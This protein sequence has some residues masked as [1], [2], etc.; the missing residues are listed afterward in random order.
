MA[1]LEDSD[2]R[3]SGRGDSNQRKSGG[4]YSVTLSSHPSTLAPAAHCSSSSSGIIPDK[5][6][7][8]HVGVAEILH[9]KPERQAEAVH[10]AQVDDEEDD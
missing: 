10:E 9:A 8:G 4:E 7:E 1:S 2:Q 6:E 3:K 5:S